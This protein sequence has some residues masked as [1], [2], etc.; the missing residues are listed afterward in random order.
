VN[1]SA[2]FFGTTDGL[3]LH[4]VA[5]TAPWTVVELTPGSAVSGYGSPPSVD[6][7]QVY[8]AVVAGSGIG[9]SIHRVPIAG[10]TPEIVAQQDL[11]R[12]FALDEAHVYFETCDP[13]SP[14]C[15]ERWIVRVQK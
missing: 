7:Q 8:S 10:G 5:I 6:D 15:S 3:R 11:T 2:L 9:G 13:A 4:R 14:S 12:R 1:S